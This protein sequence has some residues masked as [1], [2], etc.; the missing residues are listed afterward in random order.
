M[1]K[2]PSAEEI[3]PVV[4]ACLASSLALPESEIAPASRLIDDLGA[5][6]DEATDFTRRGG[7][8][9]RQAGRQALHRP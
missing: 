6:R 8:Q 4:R 7:F 2:A 1:S 9:R 3:Y 5:E